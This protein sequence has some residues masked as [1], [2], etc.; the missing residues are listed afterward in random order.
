MNVT[1]MIDRVLAAMPLH[2]A[3]T[4]DEIWK[5]VGRPQ[6]P[7]NGLLDEALIALQKDPRISMNRYGIVRAY[8]RIA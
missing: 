1:D 7:D 3:M 2:L 5:A 6:D 4:H 8:R